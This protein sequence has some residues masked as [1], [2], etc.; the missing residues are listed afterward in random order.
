MLLTAVAFGIMVV[1]SLSGGNEGRVSALWLI[2]S[3]FV[4]TV[5]DDDADA[6]EALWE[7]QGV[8][9]ARLGEVDRRGKLEVQTEAGGFSVGVETLRKAWQ[10]AGY[11]E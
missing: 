8:P 2:A 5:A 7:K 1:A 11:W 9:F 6:F 10:K 4:V 3:Y